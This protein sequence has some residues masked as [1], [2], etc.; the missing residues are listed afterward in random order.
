MPLWLV[1]WGVARPNAAMFSARLAIAL[2]GSMRAGTR[3]RA[4]GYPTPRSRLRAGGRGARCLSGSRV[5]RIPGGP[6]GVAERCDDLGADTQAPCADRAAGRGARPSN[7]ALRHAWR[8]SAFER[9]AR[10][11]VDR[12]AEGWIQCV[13][14]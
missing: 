14:G 10:P 6:L 5:A 9:R 4:A 7:A 8:S 12:A 1:R 11:C 3:P 2:P 13:L